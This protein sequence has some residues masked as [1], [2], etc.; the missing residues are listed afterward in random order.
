MVQHVHWV[1]SSNG[2]VYRYRGG[3]GIDARV[4]EL[5]L[6]PKFL[7]ASMMHV[8]AQWQSHELESCDLP[9]NWANFCLITMANNR[10]TKENLCKLLGPAIEDEEV[11]EQKLEEAAVVP[12]SWH[13]YE[14][15]VG[16][17]DT[18]GG[19]SSND[20]E[21]GLGT[22]RS[23]SPPK[24]APRRDADDWHS[25]YRF[26][27]EDDVV[28]ALDTEAKKWLAYLE[29][30]LIAE[31]ETLMKKV[32]HKMSTGELRK[33]SAFVITCSKNALAKNGYNV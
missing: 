16:G 27:S 12:P 10:E 22:Y 19:G 3:T 31:K 15:Y 1:E 24:K 2:C 23:W 20:H 32:R 21:A 14:D 4:L 28:E 13:D 8:V 11:V 25:T 17:G 9:T 18:G 5:S 26:W 6:V 7:V 30:K 33:C 29:R